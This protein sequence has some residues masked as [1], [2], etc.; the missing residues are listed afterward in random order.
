L[1]GAGGIH[2]TGSLAHPD[3]SITAN[4]K[5]SPHKRAQV[6]DLSASSCFDHNNRIGFGF[7]A[8]FRAHYSIFHHS[9]L[10]VLITQYP[11]LKPETSRLLITDPA[12]CFHPPECHQR[13][14]SSTYC[15]HDDLQFEGWAFYRGISNAYMG[16]LADFASSSTTWVEDRND[17]PLRRAA[18]L[19]K[20]GRLRHGGALCVLAEGVSKSNSTFPKTIEQDLGLTEKVRSMGGAADHD[21]PACVWVQAQYQL[22]CASDVCPLNDSRH[23]WA[24]QFGRDIEL[25]H[26]NEND[27]RIGKQHRR[28]L[29]CKR[30]I[31]SQNAT[32]R[33]GRSRYFSLEYSRNSQ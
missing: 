31:S 25:I 32:T 23:P 27:R 2:R 30:E 3:N 7:S 10:P 18:W 4:L 15:L 14:G 20:T 13:R 26:G 1:L 29:A 22:D 17:W 21:D 12:R 9:I 5:K 16:T 33:S 11:G 6:F 28:Q 24:A 8:S 19:R